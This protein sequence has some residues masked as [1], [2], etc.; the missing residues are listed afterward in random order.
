M[1]NARFRMDHGRIEYLDDFTKIQPTIDSKVKPTKID[2]D[3][4]KPAFGKEGIYKA[5]EREVARRRKGVQSRLQALE[6][7][8]LDAGFLSRQE[9]WETECEKKGLDPNETPD[10]LKQQLLPKSEYGFLDE[11]G[12]PFVAPAIPKMEEL[13]VKQKNVE[14]KDPEGKHD[15]LKKVTGMTLQNIFDLKTKVLVSHRVVNQTRLGKI[16]SIYCLA[17]AGNGQGMLGIGEGK[18]TEADEAMDKARYQA[19]KAMK[20]IPRYEDRTI[21]GEVESKVSAT[22]VKLMSRPPGKFNSSIAAIH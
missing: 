15:R 4:L 21:Y 6:M 18:A 2:P 5:E 11:Y 20:P 3:L 8:A 14:E 12:S 7:A 22:V 10:P 9:Q 16:Q 13:Q 1:S 19:M 17:I